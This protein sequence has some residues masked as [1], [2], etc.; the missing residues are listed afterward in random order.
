MAAR[1]QAA[2]AVTKS[3]LLGVLNNKL[4]ASISTIKQAGAEVSSCF[5]DAMDY[6]DQMV[7]SE[8]LKSVTLVISRFLLALQTIKD[9]CMPCASILVLHQQ[10]QLPHQHL[11][12]PCLLAARNVLPE[13]SACAWVSATSISTRATGA[14]CTG[15]HVWAWAYALHLRNHHHLLTNACLLL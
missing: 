9:D 12:L 1:L 13:A 3:G 11:E 15:C 4:D 10:L 6:V 14:R 2:V 8:Q 7:R 5:G